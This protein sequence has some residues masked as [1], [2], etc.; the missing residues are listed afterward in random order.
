MGETAWVCQAPSAA[1][2]PADL[3]SV[4]IWCSRGCS[5]LGPATTSP[6]VS[7][8]SAPHHT[9]VCFSDQELSYCNVPLLSH[10]PTR[11][12]RLL[13]RTRTGPGLWEGHKLGVLCNL[14]TLDPVWREGLQSAEYHRGLEGVAKVGDP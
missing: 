8:S 10:I 13:T 1:V 11:P 2:R 7:P 4:S 6:S 12:T 3:Q 9:V 14:E 5:R